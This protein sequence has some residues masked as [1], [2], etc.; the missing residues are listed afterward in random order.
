MNFYQMMPIA[1][2][3]VFA[4]AVPLAAQSAPSASERIAPSSAMVFFN[5]NSIA[6][7]P[8]AHSTLT[9]IA[10][11]HASRPNAKMRVIGI[12]NGSGQ[13]VSRRSIAQRRA[14]VVRDHLVT[15]GISSDLI[16]T[17]L[18]PPRLETIAGPG[19]RRPSQRRVEVHIV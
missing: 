5:Y 14:D 8:A 1:V 10:T 11:V 13:E 17:S 6:I 18:E 19:Q 15:L 7:T 12:L 2:L 4:F 3:S 9:S 16:T